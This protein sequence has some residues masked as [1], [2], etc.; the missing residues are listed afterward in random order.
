MDTTYQNAIAGLAG[1]EDK[2]RASHQ[3]CANMRQ[4]R[5]MSSSCL[6]IRHQDDP[7][8]VRYFPVSVCCTSDYCM[9]TKD[10]NA[11]SYHCHG[12]DECFLLKEDLKVQ[13]L[14]KAS[15]TM[16]ECVAA[17]SDENGNNSDMQF[18]NGGFYYP[19]TS[20][21]LRESI[22]ENDGTFMQ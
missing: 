15:N 17:Y 21:S 16:A 9:M 6:P 20:E 5:S 4:S 1:H 13:A 8:N 22:C 7:T 10:D 14:P 11:F 12:D 3:D 2:I 18:E 19:F